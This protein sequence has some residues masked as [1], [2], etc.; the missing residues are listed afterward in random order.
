MLNTIGDLITEVLVRNGVQTTTT[1]SGGLYTDTIL[2][3][4]VGTAHR[5]A[6]SLYPW[7]FTEG[8]S[9]TTYTQEE[10][11]YPEGFKTNSIRFI[12]VGG[13]KYTKTNFEQ[14]QRFREDNPQSTEKIFTDFARVYLINPSS[15]PGG[16]IVAYGQY[17]VS[18]LDTTDLNA[19]TVFS[20][21]EEDGNEAIVQEM[22]S[23]GKR[24][25]KKIPEADELHKSALEL[26]QTVWKR[27][28]DEQFAYQ[29]DPI[30]EGMWK[31]INV[32]AGAVND[33]LI[34]RDQWY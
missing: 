6:A 24:R 32:V 17:L 34:K 7:P 25:E 14:Y 4:W 3:S 5:W 10:M 13:K 12:Q 16:T 28:Q 21:A 20:N 26:L 2:A 15:S 29:P 8:R 18:P 23:F 30:G 31:R 9:N 22:C 19:L 33:Q 11:T 27:Y 1:A